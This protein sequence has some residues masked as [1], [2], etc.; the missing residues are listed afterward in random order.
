MDFD[1]VFVANE[2]QT[3]FVFTSTIFSLTIARA[4]RY[5]DRDVSWLDEPIWDVIAFSQDNDMVTMATTPVREEA[6]HAL[7]VHAT[8]LGLCQ[9]S[10][11]IW[12][13]PRLVKTIKLR[14]YALII[15][16]AH[17]T[18]TSEAEGQAFIARFKEIWS[19]C[20]L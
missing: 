1:D 5:R 11:T 18:I 7:A 16:Q 15:N 19:Q 10:D 17:H 12:V 6:R 8:K 3:H 20:S 2:D 13:N 14:P 4:E 9:V